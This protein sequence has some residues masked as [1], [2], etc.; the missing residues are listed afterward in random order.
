V[1]TPRC[2]PGTG[3]VTRSL[4][5]QWL[6]CCCL[7]QLINTLSTLAS[8][9]VC[10]S[11]V[12]SA[13]IKKA[14]PT[15]LA[16]V[17]E[18]KTVWGPP[19]SL[20]HVPDEPVKPSGAVLYDL[21]PQINDF[22]LHGKPR[23]DSKTATPSLRFFNKHIVTPD[24]VRYVGFIPL[25]LDIF[26]LSVNTTGYTDYAPGVANPD[27]H[28]TSPIV[29]WV[30]KLIVLFIICQKLG[31]AVSKSGTPCR[32]LILY[33]SQISKFAAQV[34]HKGIQIHLGVV[35]GKDD[36]VSIEEFHAKL[37]NIAE[38]FYVTKTRVIRHQ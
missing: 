18:Y 31:E 12:T 15:S 35:L 34:K 16:P 24:L 37:S 29:I 23:R 10:Q 8:H 2:Q 21:L 30:S 22:K 26:G 17:E 32:A 5:R 9:S 38:V 4:S 7:P 3:G 13:T 1:T 28:V 25:L 14:K 6:C 19:L 27:T 36:D 11:P 33:T 20:Q